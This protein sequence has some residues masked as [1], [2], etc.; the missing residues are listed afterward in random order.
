MWTLS[1]NTL[2][3]YNLHLRLV[4]S[5]GAELQ[6]RWSTLGLEHPQIWVSGQVLE[7]TPCVFQGSTIKYFPEFCEPPSQLIE[8]KEGIMGSL[9]L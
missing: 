9:D 7:P 6:V 5:S 2:V 8:P 4:V 3:L 1:I